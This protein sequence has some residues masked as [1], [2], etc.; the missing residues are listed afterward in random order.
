MT[1]GRG[2]IAIGALGASALFGYFE[3]L[4]L[5]VAVLGVPHLFLNVLP[6]IV[7]ILVL[8]G[9]VRRTQPPAADGVPY[10]KGE[11]S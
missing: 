9:F 3:A 11:A 7:M 1:Q 4:S 6:H 10:V 5:R 2:F 8:A